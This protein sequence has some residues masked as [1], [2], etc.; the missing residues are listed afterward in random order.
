MEQRTKKPTLTI[1]KKPIPA[2]TPNVEGQHPQTFPEFTEDRPTDD[3]SPT[4]WLEV[5]EYYSQRKKPH[6]NN[7]THRNEQTRNESRWQ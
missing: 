6:S 5:D 3:A 7:R 2:P 1:R 4:D